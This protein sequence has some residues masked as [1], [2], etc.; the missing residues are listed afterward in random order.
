MDNVILV[1]VIDG[2]ENLLDC[3]RGI[4][5]GELAPV[6]N[7]IEELASCC[8]LGDDIELVL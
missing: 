6:T 8:Q 5:L 1:K 4:L 7:T 2:V 3:L